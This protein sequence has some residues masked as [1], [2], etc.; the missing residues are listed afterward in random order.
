MYVSLS[1]DSI[2]L[3]PSKK[4]GRFPVNVQDFRGQVLS[5]N[6]VVRSIGTDEKG[7]RGSGRMDSYRRLHPGRMGSYRRLRLAGSASGSVREGRCL[8]IKPRFL[9]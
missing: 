4:L 8:G 7:E 9:H 2:F 6:S 1:T 3:L 5:I